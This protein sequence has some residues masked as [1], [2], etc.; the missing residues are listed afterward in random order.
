MTTEKKPFDPSAHFRKVKGGQDYL[1]CKY[2]LIWWRE[3]HPEGHVTTDLIHADYANGYYVVKARVGWTDEQ[4][5]DVHATAHKSESVK[6]FAEAL[7]KAET[8]AI[9][10]ALALLGYGTAQA[11]EFDEGDRIVDSPVD[12]TPPVATPRPANGRTTTVHNPP[13]GTPQRSTLAI[14]PAATTHADLLVAVDQMLL[15]D[16]DAKEKLPKAPEH[17]TEEELVKTLAWLKRRPQPASAASALRTIHDASAE[18]INALVEPEDMPTKDNMADW[19]ATI[20]AAGDVLVSVGREKGGANAGHA[21]HAHTLLTTMSKLA[22]GLAP[23]MTKTY[24]RDELLTMLE[25]TRAAMLERLE[26]AAGGKRA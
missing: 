13:A 3:E 10:R 16:P 15:A 25:S 2:R 17:M 18:R 21:T 4:G 9:G 24:S 6:D 5:R 26:T 11:M 23:D 20:N 1:E 8:G 12:R 19:T 7:E 22:P 14:V